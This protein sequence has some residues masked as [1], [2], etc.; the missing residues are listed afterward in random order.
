MTLYLWHVTALVLVVGLAYWLG[1]IGLGS[2]PNSAAWWATRPLWIALLSRGAPTVLV[3]VFGRFE[4]R[5]RVRAGAPPPAWHSVAGALASAEVSPCSPSVASGLPAFSASA[6]GSAAHVRR[7][8]AVAGGWFPRGEFEEL[9]RAESRCPPCRAVGCRRPDALTPASLRGPREE[10]RVHRV[11][12]GVGRPRA[13]SRAAARRCAA[14]AGAQLALELANLRRRRSLL[15]R[16]E[17][18]PAPRAVAPLKSSD[19][20]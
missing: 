10:P 18:A 9:G 3:A 7:L 8:H 13:R 4:Q 1:G 5:A 11:R 15:R 17:Q 2:V 6:S 14:D 19:L 12:A 16:R 20:Q